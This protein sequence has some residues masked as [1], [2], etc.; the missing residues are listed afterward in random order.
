MPDKTSIRRRRFAEA[1]RIRRADSSSG[2]APGA[3][4]FSGKPAQENTLLPDLGVYLQPDPMHRASV[5][6]GTGPQAYAYASGNPVR[7]SDPSG[8]KFVTSGLHSTCLAN[9]KSNP[10]IGARISAME[11][12]NNMIFDI[13]E[14]PPTLDLVNDGG[15]NTYQVGPFIEWPEP[16]EDCD[17]AISLIRVNINTFIAQQVNVT[18]PWPMNGVF[19]DDQDVLLAH[20]LGHAEYIWKHGYRRSLNGVTNGNALMFEN[21]MRQEYGMPYRHVH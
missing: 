6:S 15:G 4:L 5:M 17:G 3:G 1:T 19:T 7:Y 18:S 20:E 9:L 13:A 16:G 2:I 8:L 14:I 21:A 11:A 10:A 12:A